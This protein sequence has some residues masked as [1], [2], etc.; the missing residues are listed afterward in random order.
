MSRLYLFDLAGAAAGCLLLVPML[1]L[2]GAIDSVLATAALALV[3][4]AAERTARAAAAARDRRGARAR[5]NRATGTLALR[6]SKGLT[7]Q[8]ILFSRWNSFSRVTVVQPED[9]DRQ[10]IF[11]D[12]DAATVIYRD[13]SDN[14]KNAGLRDRIEGLAYQLGGRGK[15]LIIGP[16]GGG[17]VMLAR[18]Y[19]ARQVTAVEINPIIARD[20]MSR[21]RSGATLA[22]STS[23]RASAWSSTR[24][25]AS[26]AAAPSATT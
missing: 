26:C 9:K 6:E 25:A 3:G 14:E 1:G 4:A 20:V 2:L 24:G 17:D 7:E 8:G 19:G 5:L 12:S 23:S 10:L 13:G 18:L 21:S 16:G 22:G 15:V 11:I